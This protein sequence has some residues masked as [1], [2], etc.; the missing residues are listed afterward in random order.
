MLITNPTKDVYVDN[1]LRN[2][3]I[4]LESSRYL[5]A[6]RFKSVTLPNRYPLEQCALQLAEEKTAVK[7]LVDA[8]TQRINILIM[9]YYITSIP[10][11]ELDGVGK[12]GGG[13][14]LDWGLLGNFTGDHPVPYVGIPIMHLFP[15]VL[16]SSSVFI[17]VVIL[18]VR[19]LQSKKSP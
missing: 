6:S 16:I 8:N 12:F 5:C 7:Q 14:H 3:D 19:S 9:S 13:L 10:V 4:V 15:I 17:I 1:A 2:H 11:V 18:V